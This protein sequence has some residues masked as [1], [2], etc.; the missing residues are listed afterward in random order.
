MTYHS[1][2]DDKHFHLTLVL[3]STHMFFSLSHSHH[4]VVLYSLSRCQIFSSLLQLL[5]VNTHSYALFTYV[6]NVFMFHEELN[7]FSWGDK[8]YSSSS[9]QIPLAHLYLDA[10]GADTL[11][12]N[13]LSSSP[14][15]CVLAWVL[16]HELES[17]RSME[18]LS[19]LKEWPGCVWE[20]KDLPV[21]RVEA[22][23]CMDAILTTSFKQNPSKRFSLSIPAPN[24][25]FLSPWINPL[26]L[27]QH[28][29]FCSL[30]FG[31]WTSMSILW[32]GQDEAGR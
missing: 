21:G 13:S 26:H 25:Y 1:L 12:Q 19:P 23:P 18:Y 27:L 6:M 10:A 16:A 32:G 14:V 31:I 20:V 24:I 17:K 22:E 2:E 8:K 3:G 30:C 29:A 15:P 28:A 4:S 7:C 5:T 9:L 11:R